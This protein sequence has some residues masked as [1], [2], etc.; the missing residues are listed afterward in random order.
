MDDHHCNTFLDMDDDYC[1]TCRGRDMG[2]DSMTPTALTLTFTV[3]PLS[4]VLQTVCV[5]KAINNKVDVLCSYDTM[6][7]IQQVQ[8]NIET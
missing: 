3:S 2:L 6:M 8:I 4:P 1:N 5:Q 7:M